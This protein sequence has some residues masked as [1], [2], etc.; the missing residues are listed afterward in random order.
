METLQKGMVVH[1]RTVAGEVARLVWE[2]HGDSVEVCSER[3][4]EALNRGWEAPLPIG[5]PKT[6]VRLSA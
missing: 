5:F 6:D 3:Q 1:V 2:D 4:F